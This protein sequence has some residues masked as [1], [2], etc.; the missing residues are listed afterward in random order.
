MFQNNEHK[1][2]IKKKEQK[3]LPDKEEN[4]W[5]WYLWILK[6]ARIIDVD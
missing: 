2:Q 4:F 1:K 5:E 3:I 6:E